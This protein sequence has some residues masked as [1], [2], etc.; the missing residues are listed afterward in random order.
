MLSYFGWINGL[1]A[2]GILVFNVI[3]GFLFIYKSRETKVTLLTYSGFMIIFSGLIFLGPV[4][5]FFSIL[6][7]NFNLDN[8]FGLYGIL[9][10]IWTA[11][12]II[13]AIYIGAELVL[14]DHQKLLLIIFLSY[15]SSLNYLSVFTH[16]PNLNL[17]PP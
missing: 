14:P 15:L 2:T 7:T 6:I 13:T 12:L 4:I 8:S 11:P 17:Q 10:Y 5:D 16:Y 9:S 1:L 3:I